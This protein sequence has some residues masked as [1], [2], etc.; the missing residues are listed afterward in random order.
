MLVDE[1]LREIAEL[2]T[3][4]RNTA[5]RVFHLKPEFESRYYP[6]YYYYNQARPHDINSALLHKLKA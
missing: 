2:K 1:V 3:S 6:F 5:K 4:A